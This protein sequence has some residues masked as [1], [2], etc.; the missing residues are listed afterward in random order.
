MNRRDFLS[1]TGGAALFATLPGELL[2]Q[3]SNPQRSESVASTGVAISGRLLKAGSSRLA[4]TPRLSVNDKKVD[5]VR[6][7]F[8]TGASCGLMRRCYRRR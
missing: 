1:G 4:A 5:G 7:G 3:V 8:Q 2:P 6:R